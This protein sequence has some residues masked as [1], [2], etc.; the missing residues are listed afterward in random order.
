[1]LLCFVLLFGVTSAANVI[2]TDYG[3]DIGGGGAFG[4]YYVRPVPKNCRVGNQFRIT[5]GQPQ[6]M[7]GWKQW[8]KK[9]YREAGHKNWKDA[10]EFCNRH[11]AHMFQPNDREEYQWVENN[12]MRHNE[13]H[14]LG[15]VCNSRGKTTNVADFYTASGEDMREI[16]K[17]LNARMYP[18]HHV[19]N[20]HHPC[21]LCHRHNNSW[22][23]QYHHS[24]CN[25]GRKNV[26]EAPMG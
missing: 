19:D 13:W 6:C 25:E 11:Q 20:H 2:C 1:M 15:T 16:Q 8:R 9:C 7:G 21:M 12:V 18:G 22:R 3:K 26:C 4:G 14:F 10:E 17:K 24:S 5:K 23:W